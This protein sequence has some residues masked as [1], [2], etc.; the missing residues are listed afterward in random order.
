M[1][2]TISYWIRKTRE[3]KSLTQL[4]AADSIGV[5]R[6]T[7]VRWETHVQQPD[8]RILTKLAHWGACDVGELLAML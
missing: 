3:S 7:W 6:T 1:P 4:Q 5:H 2:G 8:V